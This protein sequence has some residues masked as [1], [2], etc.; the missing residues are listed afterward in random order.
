[1]RGA[2]DH[3]TGEHLV[4]RPLLQQRPR[5]QPG[6]GDPRQ[7]DRSAGDL[8]LAQRPQMRPEP[9]PRIPGPDDIVVRP[10]DPGDEHGTTDG[11]P[12]PSPPS[13]APATA[14]GL[15]YN[16]TVRPA[17]FVR[18]QRSRPPGAAPR[19]TAAPRA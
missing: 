6:R 13:A 5:H 11:R 16:A 4:E 9:P 12:H 19:S 15:G 14:A 1:M 17:K 18:S 3:H 8:A 10:A 2:R 7:L